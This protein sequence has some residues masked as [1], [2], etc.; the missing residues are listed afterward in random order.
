MQKHSSQR[1][2]RAFLACGAQWAFQIL[3]H[4]LPVAVRC[5]GRMLAI[6]AA[7]KSLQFHLE[8]IRT[9]NPTSYLSSI[10]SMDVS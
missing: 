2:G 5:H 7:Y 4:L 10:F 6:A 3:L 9:E 8:A 1:C